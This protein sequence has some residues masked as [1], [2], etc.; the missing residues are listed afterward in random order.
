MREFVEE[1]TLLAE[2]PARVQRW[3]DEARGRAVTRS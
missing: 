1:E 3:F 2:D